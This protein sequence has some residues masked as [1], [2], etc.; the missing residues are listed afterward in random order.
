MVEFEGQ[1]SD[2]FP[3]VQAN[4]SMRCW[5]RVVAPSLAG[6]YI[7]Q[8]TMLQEAVCWFENVRPDILQEFEVVASGERD[9]RAGTS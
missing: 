2:L 8:T 1:R 7:L 4:D 6:K 3:C 5:I 9:Q